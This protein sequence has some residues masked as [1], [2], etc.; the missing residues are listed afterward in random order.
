[1]VGLFYFGTV[2]FLSSKIKR[3]LLY[4]WKWI[5]I[6][7]IFRTMICAAALAVLSGC[8]KEAPTGAD[9]K[10]GDSLPDFTVQMADGTVVSDEDLKG[11]ISFVMFFHT[12]CPDCQQ[13]LPGVQRVYDEYASNSVRFALVSREEGKDEIEA[14]W[15][16]A[17]Y[18]M[19]YSPQETRDVY[20][21]FAAT[22]IP[23][24]FICDKDGIIR[25]MY[26][27]DPVPSYD[28]LKNSIESLIR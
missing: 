24:V 9:L 15:N 27:D 19:P 22:R 5:E 16:E 20:N 4:L 8:I 1:M 7:G 3:F 18:N 25:Y 28:D 21:L 13:T 11:S 14:Y 10:V 6:M 17:G 12:S 2:W 23:R 26:T